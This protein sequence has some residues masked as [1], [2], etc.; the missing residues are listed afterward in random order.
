[1]ENPKFID[2]NMSQLVLKWA[3]FAGFPIVAVL[4]LLRIH[5]ASKRGLRLALGEADIRS[6]ASAVL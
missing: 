2:L 1:V 5:F 4:I 3:R 6:D